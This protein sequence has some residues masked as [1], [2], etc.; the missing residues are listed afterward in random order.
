MIFHESDYFQSIVLLSIAFH[1]YVIVIVHIEIYIALTAE[2]RNSVSL[3]IIKILIISVNIH[4][5]RVKTIMGKRE[6]I[7]EEV[8]FWK[9]GDG[10]TRS[11]IITA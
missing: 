5:G 11:F 7:A 6:V 10:E 9:I 8:K 4:S 2:I 3:N 1:D